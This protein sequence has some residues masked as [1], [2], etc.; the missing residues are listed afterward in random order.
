MRMTQPTARVLD[1]HLDRR[2]F[3]QSSAQVVGGMAAGSLGLAAAAPP[4]A[5][6]QPARGAQRLSLE[7]L[8]QYQSLR[9]GMFISFD[10]QAF[11]PY[12][13]NHSKGLTEQQRQTPATVY[14]PDQLNV[15]QWIA[16]ARDAGMKYAV[17]TA[18]RHPGFCLWPSKHT[19][20]TVA[21]SGNKTDVV[22]HYVKACEK[23]GI[24]A[25]LYYPSVDIH[26]CFGRPPEDDWKYTTSGYQTFQTNQI[27]E[28]LTGY[29]SIAE[30][31]IDI[32]VV[33]GPGYRKFLYQHISS[34]QPNALIMMNVGIQDG[35]QIERLLDKFWPSDLIS[36]ERRLPP[37]GG[38]RTWWTI[39]GQDY[40]LPAEVS[41]S[42]MEKNWYWKEGEQPRSDQ[43]L[44][45]QFEACRRR[46]VNYLLDAPPDKHGL[47]PQTT[48]DA[49][50][51]LRRNARL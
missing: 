44:L 17:L 43:D 31:W 39:N 22:E 49:L 25:G 6:E 16:V 29:G 3:L 35:T 30:V 51:R 18:K 4:A 10:I 23:Y 38:H 8:K 36:I 20:Y 27:T 34:L 48:V 1:N 32:P 45:S 5:A 24:Q 12:N 40:Y 21:H 11:V 7:R 42:I 2:S 15:A 19:E 28:L 50:Q 46:G 26:H 14:A 37:E 41:D 13:L 47:I 33:L 9:Y